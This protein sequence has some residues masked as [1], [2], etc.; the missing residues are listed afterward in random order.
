LPAPERAGVAGREE[1][2]H[3][4]IAAVNAGLSACIMPGLVPG[5]HVL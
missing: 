4:L 1:I 3:V 5:I 2:E